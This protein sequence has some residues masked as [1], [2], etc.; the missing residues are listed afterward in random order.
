MKLQRAVGSTSQKLHIY[1]QD[2]TVS[3]GAGLA[4]ITANTVTCTIFR[5][6]MT[7]TSTLTCSTS[8]GTL[9]TFNVSCLTQIHATLAQG[10][11]QFCPP[12][13]AF[14]SGTSVLLHLYGAASMAPLPIEI[15]LTK[16]DMQQYVSSHQIERVLNPVTAS[17]VTAG[18]H[19]SSINAP[20]GVSSTN[21]QYR[22]S[23]LVG[24][25]TLTIPTGVSS[26]SIPF[27]VSSNTDKA[28]YGVSSISVGVNA[29]TVSGL[30]GV[31]TITV[32]VNASTVSGLVGVSTVT[33]PVSASSVTA[34]VHVSSI[35]APVGV[36]STNIRYSV[37]T[38]VGVSTLTIPAGVSSVSI[39][40]GVSSIATPVTTSSVTAL[41]GV[42]TNTD[43]SDYLLDST[44]GPAG[45]VSTNVIKMNNATVQGDG[46]A[47]NL[48]RG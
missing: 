41:V 47:G 28:D 9:G 16:F 46:T 19:V 15:E 11:Y 43:K 8:T 27:G 5:D 38:L 26:A 30:V 21:I 48:W 7:S 45:A 13:Y 33:I 31:S 22:V 18:V 25:S 2:A 14:A 17:S 12:D 10:W 40:V 37:S 3:T 44:Y 24:V 34:G 23:T 39:P 35:S 4:G 29:S 1:I 36:S 6:N 32:G 42:S 20:V